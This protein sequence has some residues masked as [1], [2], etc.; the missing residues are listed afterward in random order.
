M[1]RWPKA[2]TRIEYVLEAL[3]FANVYAAELGTPEDEKWWV[4]RS[5]LEDW[6]ALNPDDQPAREALIYLDGLHAGATGGP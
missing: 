5:Y 6:L 1:E 3:H 4:S 2:E